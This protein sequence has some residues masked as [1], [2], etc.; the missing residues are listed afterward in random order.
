MC[1]CFDEPFV[2]VLR[3]VIVVEVKAS[4]GDSDG[5]RKRVEFLKRGVGYEMPPDSTVARPQRWIDQESH[6]LRP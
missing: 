2:H 3:H 4:F 5:T 1:A 6:V